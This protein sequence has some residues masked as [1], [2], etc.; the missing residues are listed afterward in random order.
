MDLLTPSIG[1]LFWQIVAFGTLFFLLR[2]FAWKPILASLKEREDNIQSALDMA[3]KTRAEMASLKSENEK[4]LAQARSERETIL[5][6]AKE[7]ADKL[8]ADAQKKAQAE[9]D[10]IL[11][12]ARESMAN[13]RTAMVAAMKKEVVTLSIEV[14][15][16]V[17]RRE[18]V[19]KAAQEKLVQD[20]VS[21]SRL[22]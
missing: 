9:G 1:L 17:L 5:R 13:E 6:G 8:V 20:L 15:E 22:N 10:R 2:A 16:K 18:L 3:Q 21:T 12:Q 11:E 7:V 4:L 14:A 19:D